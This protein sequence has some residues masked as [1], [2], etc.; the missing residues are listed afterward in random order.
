[1]KIASNLERKQSFSSVACPL[2]K[3]AFCFR[4]QGTSISILGKHHP[5][6][7]NG[8]VPADSLVDERHPRRSSS[9]EENRRD[10]NSQRVLPLLVKAR[11][12]DERGAKPEDGDDGDNN[13]ND[14]DGDDDDDDDNDDGPW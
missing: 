1:M 14:V 8:V 2:K 11:A 10:G 6:H 12:V 7:E 3:K 5:P 9:P 13:D 4:F